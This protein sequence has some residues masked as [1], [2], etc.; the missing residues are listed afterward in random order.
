MRKAVLS[1]DSSATAGVWG[2]AAFEDFFLME[3]FVNISYLIN[4]G[5]KPTDVLCLQDNCL[6]ERRLSE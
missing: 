6:Q 5:F 2:G 3:A 4:L 1:I